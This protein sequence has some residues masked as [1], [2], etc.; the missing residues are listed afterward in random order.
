MPT[1]W[2]YSNRGLSVALLNS[3]NTNISGDIFVFEFFLMNF[4]IQLFSVV[5]GERKGK[6]FSGNNI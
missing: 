1:H 3:E 4:S 6:G 2:N 5:H